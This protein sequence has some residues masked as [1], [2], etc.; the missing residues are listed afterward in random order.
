MLM[1]DSTT[2]PAN[3]PWRGWTKDVINDTMGAKMP[4]QFDLRRPFLELKAT[5]DLRL[6]GAPK[7]LVVQAKEYG[8]RVERYT[9]GAAMFGVNLVLRGGGRYIDAQGKTHELRPG[10]LFH[11]YPGPTHATW[12]DPASDYAECFVVFDAATG[13]SLVSAGALSSTPVHD[14]GVD[15]VIL[16]EFRHLVTLVRTPEPQLS[17][18]HV[19]LAAVSF[20]A[21]LYD[22][23]RR[24]RVVDRWTKALEDGCLLLEHNLDERVRVSAIARRLGVSYA[25]FRKRFTA[26]IGYAPAD[27]RIRRRLESAQL[28]LTTSTVAATARMLGYPDPYAFSAQFRRFL[29]ISPREFQRRARSGGE[30]P[31]ALIE[32]RPALPG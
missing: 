15:A 25:A 26:E 12:F 14:I 8:K 19:L 10:V 7:V 11:R 9:H 24:N 28:S 29:G 21:G 20:V 5:R 1:T 2:L 23:A 3:E 17:S 31:E 16:D 6:D 4:G 27:Y 30:G 32:R 22:R 13:T 18:R